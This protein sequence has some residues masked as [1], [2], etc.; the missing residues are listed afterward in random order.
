[1]A[2][3]KATSFRVNEEDIAK[4]KEFTEKEGYNQAE[5]FKFIMQTVEMAK[6]KNMISD[7]AK[8]IETF[9]DTINNLMSMFLNSLN[10]NKSSE[11][12]IREELSR[13]INLKDTTITTM[14]EQLEEV[15]AENNNLKDTNKENNNNIK[16]LQDQLKKATI[17]ITDKQKNIDKLN[18]SND[19]L[20]ETLKEY[21]QY[22]D[23]YKILEK[24]LEQLKQENIKK[25]NTI[26]N[27]ENSNKQ[28]EDKLKNDVDMINFYKDNNL[29]LKNNIKDYKAEIKALEEAYKEEI[30]NIKSENQKELEKQLVVLEEQFNNKL[31]IEL[32]KKEL[33]IQ[34]LNNTLDQLQHNPKKKNNKTEQQELE[35]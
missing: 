11:E 7:R 5:A 24:E 26:S 17:D 4:F 12:R 31:S 27:L 33:E 3:I 25:D 34:K 8:E 13:E 6:A 23:N 28:L 9:Q 32:S 29:E 18:S 1:M 14:L 22:K 30:G 16:E 21:R 19:L 20:Q 2:D 35:L 10:V 15:K